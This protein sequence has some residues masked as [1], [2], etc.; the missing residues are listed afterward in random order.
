MNWPAGIGISEYDTNNAK[1]DVD[2]KDAADGVV[3]EPEAPLAQCDEFLVLDLSV[4]GLPLGKVPLLHRSELDLEVGE[5][6]VGILG[7]CCLSGLQLNCLHERE[8][9]FGDSGRYDL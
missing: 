4:H 3:S 9:L 6:K 1:Y 2:E 7:C 8:R 5:K